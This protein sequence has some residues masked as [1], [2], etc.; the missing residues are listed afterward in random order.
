MIREF[1]SESFTREGGRKKKGKYSLF[2]AKQLDDEA[3]ARAR[4][5]PSHI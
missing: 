5:A 2:L 1:K 3:L 4:T